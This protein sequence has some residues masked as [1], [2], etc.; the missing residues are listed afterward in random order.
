LCWINFETF[1]RDS[2]IKSNDTGAGDQNTKVEEKVTLSKLE[3]IHNPSPQINATWMCSIEP[4]DT[5]WL[6]TA[7]TI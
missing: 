3:I 4:T 6:M 1:G 7:T 5:V 2:Q